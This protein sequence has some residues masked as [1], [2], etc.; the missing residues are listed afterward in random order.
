MENN[1]EPVHVADFIFSDYVCVHV[2]QSWWSVNKAQEQ[3]SAAYQHTFW[4]PVLK[5]E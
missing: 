1:T 4:S 2:A 5:D 3:Q